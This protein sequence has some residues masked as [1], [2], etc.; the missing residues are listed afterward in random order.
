MSRPQIVS[1]A[2][3]SFTVPQVP[4]REYKS[5]GLDWVF[6]CNK[7]L[8]RLGILG[9]AQETEIE[10]QPSDAKL[11]CGRTTLDSIV[12][13]GFDHITAFPNKWAKI[14]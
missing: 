10:E 4:Y 3:S 9:A 5:L 8:N 12:P 6:I 2:T 11:V 13:L 14:R 1:T 7:T